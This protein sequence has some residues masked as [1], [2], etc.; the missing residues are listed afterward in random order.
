MTASLFINVKMCLFKTNILIP[1]GLQL[2]IVIN[3]PSIFTYSYRDFGGVLVPCKTSK[4]ELFAKLVKDFNYFPNKL[5]LRCL[6][7]F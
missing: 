7:G 5:R 3:Q 2:G 4:V 1:K 6:T